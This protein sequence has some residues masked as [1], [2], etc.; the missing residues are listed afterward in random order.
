MF[1]T[2]RLFTKSI[3][4]DC[5]I[6]L[7]IPCLQKFTFSMQCMQAHV[8]NLKI[9]HTTLAWKQVLSRHHLNNR[10]IYFIC[11]I[12]TLICTWYFL[13]IFMFLDKS[14]LFRYNETVLPCCKGVLNEVLNQNGI[15]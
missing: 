7:C 10:G 12:L 15:I 1:E 5:T 14:R 8:L 11:R 13:Y 9:R 4:T 2:S 3:L 6:A